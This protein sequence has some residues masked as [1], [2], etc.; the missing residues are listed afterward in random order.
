MRIPV[1]CWLIGQRDREMAVDVL[2]PGGSGRKR[3]VRS[4][5]DT[6]KSH[7]RDGGRMHD[8][9]IFR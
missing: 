5:G 7:A 3:C 1:L 6:T 2:W 9:S 4:Y 8:L